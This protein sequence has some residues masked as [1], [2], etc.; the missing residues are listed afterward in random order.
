MITPFLKK[1]AYTCFYHL[2]SNFKYYP[3]KHYLIKSITILIEY[4][5]SMIENHVDNLLKLLLQYL[6]DR[7]N[8]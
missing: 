1:I 2:S 6:E 3:E 4:A 5:P 8:Y 7:N